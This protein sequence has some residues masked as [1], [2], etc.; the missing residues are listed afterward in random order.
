MG[1]G[2]LAHH[3]RLRRVVGGAEGDVVDRA[4]A[5]PAAQ[6]AAG[7]LEV[8]DAAGRASPALSG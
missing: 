5:L 6:E 7:L 3:R 1:R 2:Q 8:D 4:G